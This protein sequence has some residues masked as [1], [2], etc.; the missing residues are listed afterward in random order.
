M[1]ILVNKGIKHKPVA[2]ENRLTTSKIFETMKDV[3]EIMEI[4]HS[5][6]LYL[7]FNLG[8]SERVVAAEVLFQLVPSGLATWRE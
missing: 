1:C 3:S 7:K 4:F 5:Q 6:D 2:H 8:M